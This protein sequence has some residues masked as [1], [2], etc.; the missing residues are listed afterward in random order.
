MA[1]KLIQLVMTNVKVLIAWL[2]ESHDPL[3]KVSG[4]WA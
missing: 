1:T 2:P 4:S 3:S